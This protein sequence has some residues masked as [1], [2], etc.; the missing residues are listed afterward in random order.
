MAGIEVDVMAVES[1]A[2]TLADLPDEVRDAIVR[3]LSKPRH[4]AAAR[5]ASRLLGGG[6]MEA[7]T[8][9]WAV[10]HM[11]SL[12]RSEAPLPLIAAVVDANLHLVAFDTLYAAVLG[13]RMD[14]L[15]MVHA[16]LEVRA[17]LFAVSFRAVSSSSPL[18]PTAR[19]RLMRTC[20]V[21]RFF[22]GCFVVDGLLP[23][24][25]ARSQRR[26]PTPSPS[27]Y[28][29]LVSPIK[30]ALRGGHV[31]AA[32]Y[33]INRAVAGVRYDPRED[34]AL[35]ATAAGSGHAG[36]MAFAHD[37]LPPGTGSAPCSCQ[38]DLGDLAWAAPLPGAA[39]WLKEHGCGGYVA[40][41]ARHL[42]AALAR[43]HDEMLR[44]VLAEIDPALVVPSLEIDQALY[45]MSPFGCLSTISVAVEA[46]LIARP[47]PIFASAGAVG[48]TALLDYAA[49]RFGTPRDAMRGAAI[50]A[51]G[52]SKNQGLD[53]IQWIAARRPD[54]ID[55][56]I[57]WTAIACAS[58][59]VVRAIDDVL[60]VPF[61]WQRAAHAVL[62]RGSAKLLRYAVEEK[63]MVI[64]A[65]SVQGPVW[66]TAKITRYMLQRWGIEQVQPILD[67]ASIHNGRRGRTDWSWLDAASG[68]CTA[69]RYIAASARA[70][71]AIEVPCELPP[72]TC[73]RC[74]EA[75]GSRPPKR[76]R[77]DP[78][79][80]PAMSPRP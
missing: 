4:L 23:C 13:E 3:M 32:R 34:D 7:L 76:Q 73:R 40:P 28:Y 60:A 21:F 64:D 42:R 54:V 29:D 62:H 68:A 36:A 56:P 39:L 22:F 46:G 6:D 33:L 57:M 44:A 12:V 74:D 37:R 35:A 41:T 24:A 11:F 72:C 59:D 31:D 66:L 10:R 61:D 25:C 53:A 78:V 43:Q 18:P 51:A 9:R 48:Y 63:A 67:A 69:E 79:A 20:R 70:L 49:A 58:V 1:S 65:M 17:H 30:A 45:S 75:A 14:V 15:R 71:Y 77:P 50:A 16:A 19:S 38:S 8:M 47:L 55:S 27:G 26:V 80:T 5:C 2:P 52:A